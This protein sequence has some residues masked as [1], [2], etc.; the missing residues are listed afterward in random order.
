MTAIGTLPAATARA[1]TMRAIVQDRYG[2]ADV[3]TM[4]EIARPEPDPEQVL[5][6]VRATSVNALDWHLMRGVPIVARLSDGF[7]RPRDPVRG[8][9]VAGVVEAVGSNVT[10]L[11]VGDEVFGS[12]TGALAEYVAGRTFEPKPSNLTFEEAAALP[13][14]GYTA[15][16]GL[17]DRGRLEA[18]MRVLVTGAGGG[19]G[20]LA[21]QIANALGAHVTAVTRTPNLE[22]VAG[23]GA[24]RVVDDTIGDFTRMDDRFDVIA[25]CSGY[26][27]LADLTRL[28]APGGRL[29]MIGAGRGRGIGLFARLIN[30]FLRSRLGKRSVVPFLASPT[31]SDLVAL[32]ELAEAGRLRPVIDRTYPLAEA[33]DAIRYLETGRVR[34]KLV[35]TI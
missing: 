20:H 5:V 32:R 3:L 13:T 35:V 2:S 22:M 9:D 19:V 7:L 29:V 6:R 15:L 23:L 14:A 24:D 1:A 31:R 33:A 26:R 12:R 27:S 8:V 25:D 21:V 16:Q 17:R 28:L 34:G 4:R 18:G 30:G 10:H 11:S